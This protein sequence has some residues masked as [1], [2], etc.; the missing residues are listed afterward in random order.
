MFESLVIDRSAY[1]QR[2]FD[3]WT[4]S[5]RSLLLRR[6]TLHRAMEDV[7]IPP[8]AEQMISLLLG[9]EQTAEVET[10]G[11]WR[12]GRLGPGAISMTAPNRPTRI[13]WHALSP[14]PLDVLQLHLP[15]GTTA[16]IVEELWDCDPAH[17]RFPDTLTTPDPVLRQTML[18]LLRA[19]KAGAPDLY[20]ESAAEFIT[21]HTLLGHG[22]VSEL[23][24]YGGEDARIRR[25][26]TY[27]R[28]N[29]ARPLSLA[30]VA[31][32]VGMSRYHFLRTFRQ[33]TG[34]TPHRY[35][36]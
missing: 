32:E 19:A 29:L 3:S 5:W 9:G 7:T 4:C 25:A 16:R 11:H 24:V 34:Q 1:S 18:G 33:Q 30:G 27:L 35:L 10:D 28:E 12:S 8:V 14:A 17:M 2:T 15:A 13:R 36:T 6:Y 31:A 22:N 26:R 20:A 23:R 21:V